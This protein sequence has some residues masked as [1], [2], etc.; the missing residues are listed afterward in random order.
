MM[1]GR[2]NNFVVVGSRPWNRR[3]FDEEIRRLPGEWHYLGDRNDVTLSRLSEIA[4]EY[5]FFLHWSWAVPKEIVDRFE[6]VC[7]H[8]TD[9]PYGR[10]GSP[11]QNLIRRGHRQTV[12]SAIRMTDEVDAGPVL[13]KE[14]LCL[15]GGAEEVFIRSSRLSARLIDRIIHERPEPREQTGDVVRFH[16]RTPEESELPADIE[17][18]AAMHDFIRMLDAEGYPHAFL[19]S[20][21]FRLELT[22]STLYDGRI[23]ADVTVTK[24][25]SSDDDAG[26]RG[27][28]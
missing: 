14:D 4:P 27:T 18:L 20:G 17:D 26:D 8:M 13:L 21:P 5:V 2:N 25:E 23:V 15:E 9:L 16:R 7:F 3:V 19:R 22:R 11:L 10:G 28:S 12:M 24:E 6:C 1:T